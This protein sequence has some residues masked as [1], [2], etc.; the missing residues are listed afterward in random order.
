MLVCTT[1]TNKNDPEPP[2]PQPLFL[3]AFSTINTYAAR[4]KK[5][6]YYH[7]NRGTTKIIRK[8]K[9]IKK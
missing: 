8:L 2:N 4:A 7:A 6:S 3:P 9:C 5:I 1:G